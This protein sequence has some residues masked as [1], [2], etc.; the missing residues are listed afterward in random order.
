MNVTNPFQSLV[1]ATNLAVL[2]VLARGLTCCKVQWVEI[3]LQH[4]RCEH[5]LLTSQNRMVCFTVTILHVKGSQVLFS[6]YFLF[7]EPIDFFFF[8]FFVFFAPNNDAAD[9]SVTPD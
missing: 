6:S 4:S 3:F 5:L 9:L 7:T 8:S 1:R 2:V